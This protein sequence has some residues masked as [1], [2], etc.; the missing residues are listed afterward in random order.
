MLSFSKF[1]ETGT[2]FDTA[3]WLYKSTVSRSIHAHPSYS[4]E[5]IHFY[6]F[7]FK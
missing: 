2:I 5:N 1:P 3:P 7:I 4:R 6:N